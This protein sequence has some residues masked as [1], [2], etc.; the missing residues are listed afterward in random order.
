MLPSQP[1][2]VQDLALFQDLSQIMLNGQLRLHTVS[3]SFSLV[4]R[5]LPLPSYAHYVQNKQLESRLWAK[6]R[7][8]FK[9]VYC[10][11]TGVLLKNTYWLFDF[12]D[13]IV[14]DP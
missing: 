3:F 4:Y 10:C 7:I 2:S 12:R 8:F 1:E 6:L 9:N 11:L 14:V 5:N 13:F